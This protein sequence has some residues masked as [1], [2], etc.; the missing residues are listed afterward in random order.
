MTSIEKRGIINC[1][2]PLEKGLLTKKMSRSSFFLCEWY[3]V[4]V[5]HTA[6]LGIGGKNAYIYLRYQLG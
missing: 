4:K 2:K 3:C 5:I 6:R 1:N